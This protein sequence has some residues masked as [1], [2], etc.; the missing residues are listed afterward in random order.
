MNKEM[1]SGVTRHFITV[2]AGAVLA[3]GSTSLDTMVATLLQNLASGDAKAITGTVISIAAILWSM[4][5]K[6]AD[7]TKQTVVK[8][9]TL[10]LK[11]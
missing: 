9:A 6:S 7:E 10:G 4:W 1:V 8:V 5:S 2:I 11:K 3:S